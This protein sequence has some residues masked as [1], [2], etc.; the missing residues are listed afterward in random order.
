MTTLSVEPLKQEES[1]KD[2]EIEL[3]ATTTDEELRRFVLNMI[4]FSNVS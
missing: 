3:K 1:Q 2:N 4:E